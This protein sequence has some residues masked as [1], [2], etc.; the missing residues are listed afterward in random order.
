M[1]EIPKVCRYCGFTVVFTDNSEIYGKC[2]G[3]GKVYLCRNCGAY[4]GTH[5]GGKI[6]LGT[7]ADEELR[8]MRKEAHDAFDVLW[9]QKKM[10][11]AKAYKWLA[12]KME[13]PS[14]K[15]HIAMFEIEQCKKVIELLKKI[16]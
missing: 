6:P 12:E 2:Y 8:K 16:N 13:L 5:K 3:G 15:T 10:S 9:K 11:R 4:V 7:L 14:E 1:I